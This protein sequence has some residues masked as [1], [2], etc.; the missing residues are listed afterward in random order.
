MHDEPERPVEQVLH[1]VGRRRRPCPRSS[2]ARR[3]RR[4]RPSPRRRPAGTASPCSRIGCSTGGLRGGS[5][6]PCGARFDAAER[7]TPRGTSS[8]KRVARA[9][10]SRR[11]GRSS[12]RPAK[13]HDVAGLA[14]A[15]AGPR[16]G[17]ARGRRSDAASPCRRVAARCARRPRR[18]GRRAAALRDAAAQRARSPA[19]LPWPP[20]IRCTRAGERLE[21]DER[22]GD[23]RGLR[24]VD[25]EHAVDARPTSSSR[26][27]TPANVAQRLAHRVADRR[28]RASATAAAA[29][30]VLAGCGRPRSRSSSARAAARPRHRCAVA[31]RE[32]APARRRHAPRQPPGTSMPAGATATSS[33][34]W[35]ANDLQ[36]GVAVGLER[37]VAVEVVG[38]RGSAARA[39]SGAN[40]SVSS[41]WKRRR[42]A[43][44][45]RVRGRARPTSD[46]SG[47]PTL[48]PTA[49]GSPAA[50]WIV[51]EQLDRRRLAV[52]ARSPRRTRFGSRRQ[53]SS[54]SPSTGMPALA[55]RGDRPAPRAARPGVFTT[56]PRAVEQRPGRPVPTSRLDAR[57]AR[58]GAPASTP[59][60]SLAARAAAPRRGDA[61]AREARRRGRARAAAA[62]ARRQAHGST[63]GRA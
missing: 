44:D 45:R 58:R 19:P 14:A 53:A 42:L 25:V 9:P 36:L 32:L 4:C 63:A 33:R 22:R 37:A 57:R 2:D 20:R 24:V 49:T 30:G 28:P 34:P 12:R 7:S 60:T 13:Q 54:S 61:R 55:R 5:A 35:C 17:R 11:T 48:P 39:A 18:S 10:R 3:A 51:A 16:H 26:C 1:E 62:G 15:R 59:I 46:D 47:V 8:L 38:A 50:R 40:A 23:V 21:R 52:R 29:I 41:S 56:A 31:R 27:S 43:D 6:T